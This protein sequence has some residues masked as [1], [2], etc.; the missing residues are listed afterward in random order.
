MSDCVKCGRPLDT[1]GNC[2][3]WDYSSG[4]N[5]GKIEF[6]PSPQQGWECPRC[7]TIHAPW[8]SECLCQ[9]PVGTSTEGD[10]SI[11]EDKK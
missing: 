8:V 2:D 9:P 1:T 4:F 6:T 10:T 11:T 5:I 3:C 7:R